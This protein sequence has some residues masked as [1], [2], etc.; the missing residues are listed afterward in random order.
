MTKNT[1]KS[2]RYYSNKQEEEVV[3]LTN[4]YKVSNS[5]AGKFKKGD[6]C[7]DTILYECKTTTTNKEQF[8]IKKEW[9]EKSRK[10]A[11][12]MGKDFSVLVFN[13]GPNTKNYFVVDE[14][15]YKQILDNL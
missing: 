14:R 9:L 15:F 7:S 13:F 10:E 2:T 8:T 3:K 5:G 11:F 6:V 4:S 1:N 12:E